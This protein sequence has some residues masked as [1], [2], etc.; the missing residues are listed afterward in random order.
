MADFRKYLLIVL[1]TIFAPM[2][3]WFTLVSFLI[4]SIVSGQ[5]TDLGILAGNVLNEKG[6][7]LEG[8]T[9]QLISLEDTARITAAATDKSGAFELNAIPFGYHRLR[10]SYVGLQPIILDSIYFRADRYDFN[11][12]D[13]VMRPRATDAGLEEV[14]VYAEKPLIQSKDGNI[15]FNAGESPL[16]AG[17]S[18]SDLL[19]NVPLVTKDPSGKL[20]V[21]GKEPKILIDDKPVELNQQ[22]LQDLLESLPGSSIE[23]IEVMT[24]PPAQYANEQGGVIN[25]VTK[26]GKVGMGGRVTLNVGTRGESGLN[27]NFNYRK[28]G[29]SINL[30]TG[31]SY[32][33]YKSEG[34]SLRENIYPDSVNYFN[35]NSNSKNKNVRPNFRA[36]VDYDI[37]KFQSINVALQY[38]QNG[39]K[40][41]NK[42]AYVNS[43][44]LKEVYRRSERSIQS[45]GES[46][47]PNISFSYTLKT[48][49][50]GET[51]RII[52]NSNLS[53][54]ENDRNFYQQFFYPD[55]TPTGVDSTQQQ[56]NLNG[57]TGHTI[58]VNYDLL[59]GNKKTSFS[60]G[61]YYSISNSDID[62]KATYKR[63]S[64]GKILPIYS[65]SNNFK[66]HQY[67]TNYRG[68]IKQILGKE[69]SASAGLSAE[70]T[71][72]LF[73]LFKIDST[74]KNRYWSVL[75]FANINKTWKDVLSISASYRRSIRRP[76]IGELNPTVDESD[77]YNIRFGNP[78]LR[79]SLSH[80]FDLVFGHSKNSFYA[81]LGFGY[82]LVE[83]IFNA[84]RT[85]ISNDQTQTTWL[86]ISSKKEY[87]TSM[88]SGYTVNKKI[89]L[90]VSGSYTYNQYSEFD[91]VQRKFRDGGS[92]TS[93]LNTNYTLKELYNAT[94]SF[95]YNRFANP[96][97]SVKSSVSMNLGLQAKM[98]KKKVTATLNIIDPL[99]Q[100]ENRTFTYGTNF[101]TEYFSTTETR[102]YRLSLSYNFTKSTSK[103]TAASQKVMQKAIEMQQQKKV[104]K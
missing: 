7:A 32:S 24:N 70:A 66:F 12:S 27:A 16:S 46:Y 54:S 44:R 82:N 37:N 23:K 8:A 19:A 40:N 64:D 56:V 41:F 93:N 28:K 69:F 75:P 72:I 81:N 80:N 36:S 13:L 1:K 43:N 48:K 47:N 5:K 63:R 77:P 104:P 9:V 65:L 97:G 33:Q 102:N 91:K 17:S 79:P 68:S 57:S 78:G 87:Q 18:A 59:L 31:V 42:T 103:K 49:R 3:L 30:N 67:I 100:Q 61:T 52:A 39:F 11:M 25:I 20:L 74:A 22:Q 55:N 83:D 38:N 53:K 90:N 15:T 2:R 101:S 14:I 34:Y 98:M 21:K 89:R 76:G 10:I 35:T 26:K 71:S 86:N 84:L 95:T 4:F 94:G 45:A 60:T 85:R 73:E 58:R 92:F 51:L 99:R 6:K 50:P 62:V 88:W 29:L 96:Q